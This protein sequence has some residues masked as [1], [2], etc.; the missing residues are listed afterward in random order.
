MSNPLHY[1]LSIL[2][3]QIVIEASH[4]NVRSKAELIISDLFGGEL[5]LPR[6]REAGQ[7]GKE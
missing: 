7:G 3:L 4:Y 5:L 6:G 1:S 2:S